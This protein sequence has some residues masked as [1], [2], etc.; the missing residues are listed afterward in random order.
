MSFGNVQDMDVDMTSNAVS[1]TTSRPSI[2]RAPTAS[3]FHGESNGLSMVLS[4]LSNVKRKIFNKRNQTLEQQ[5][6][7][8]SRSGDA[9]QIRELL[10]QGADPDACSAMGVTALQWASHFGRAECLQVL[11]LEGRANVN[12]P[13][14]IGMTAWKLA[15]KKTVPEG[16]APA[17]CGPA[18]GEQNHFGNML[19]DGRKACISILFRWHRQEVERRPAV[20]G[21]IYHC[22]PILNL[23]GIVGDFLGAPGVRDAYPR[24]DRLSL[25]SF[26]GTRTAEDKR[27]GSVLNHHVFNPTFRKYS[28]FV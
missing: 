13:D 4:T 18:S 2:V 12:L 24:K 19:R 17:H 8:A 15:R 27:S 25:E 6:S 14:C 22:L 26:V 21:I 23:V 11:L 3:A 20:M 5:L 10:R 9:G 16:F 28:R 7:W 1:G